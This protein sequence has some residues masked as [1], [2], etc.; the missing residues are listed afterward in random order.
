MADDSDTGL[1]CAIPSGSVVAI[2]RHSIMVHAREA[3]TEER[4]RL[5]PIATR[6]NSHWR[7]YKL[8]TQRE[9]PLLILAPRSAKP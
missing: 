7:H 9:I 3:N 1:A 2:A 4:Q 6:Y 8:R 5:W